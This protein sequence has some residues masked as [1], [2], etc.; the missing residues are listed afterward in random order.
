MVDASKILGEL[1]G[2]GN[3]GSGSLNTQSGAKMLEDLLGV[4]SDRRS[5]STGGG[6]FGGD[7]PAQSGGSVSGD[8]SRST[9]FGNGQKP[10]S[11]AG[12]LGDLLGKA[13]K[14][15]TRAPSRDNGRTSGG[16]GGGPAQTGN[17]RAGS[18]QNPFEVPSLEPAVGI[19]KQSEVYLRA[20]IQAG[21][22]DGRL[23][24]KEQQV[25]MQKIGNI[26][27]EEADFIRAEMARGCNVATFIQTVPRGIEEDV[28]AISLT[29]VQLDNQREAQYLDALA[30]GLR[31]TPEQSNAI[32]D[33]LGARR[34]YR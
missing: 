18:G 13:L 33:R 9:T 4:G 6:V 21:L 12:G 14:E 17:K 34:L 29:A 27:A 28:Y 1:L 11:G 16:F 2:G 24:E 20:M 10:A 30:K 22:S 31:I 32:H 15:F 26:G 25:I 19:D 7:R 3:R 8:Q 23:D 5:D